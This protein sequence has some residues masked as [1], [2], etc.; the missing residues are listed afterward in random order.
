MKLIGKLADEGLVP[1][2]HKPLLKSGRKIPRIWILAADNFLVRIYKKTSNRMELIGEAEPNIS[3]IETE[4]NNKT[5]GRMV[6]A[7]GSTVHHKFEPNDNESRHDEL[8]FVHD[9]SK[10]LEQLETA[11]VFDRLIIVASPKMLGDLR[12][13]LSQSVKCRVIIEVDKDLTKLGNED[14]EKA[15]KKIVWF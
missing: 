3:S 2:T 11:D 6:S 12:S 5:L 14:F 13:N 15:I 4:I 10:F 1:F 8:I 9:V 7:A